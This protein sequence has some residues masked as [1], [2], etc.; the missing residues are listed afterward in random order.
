MESPMNHTVTWRF[1]IGACEKIQILFIRG[2]TAKI[3]LKMLG[4]TVHNS[5]CPG[6]EAPWICSSVHLVMYFDVLPV[7]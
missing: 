7:L 6:F 4:A 2:K 3:M 5:V 1:L